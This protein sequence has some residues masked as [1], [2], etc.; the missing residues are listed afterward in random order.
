YNGTTNR[1]VFFGNDGGLYQAGDVNMVQGTAGWTN[2]NHGLGITQFYGAA[3]NLTTGRVVG[4][5]QDN[6]TL[7]FTPAQGPQQW[8]TIYG[9]D[10]GESAADPYQQYYYGEY[11]YLQLHRS[12]NGGASQDIFH[13]ITDAGQNALFIAPFVLDPNNSSRMLAGGG[14][15]WR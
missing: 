2:L 9:G 12:T 1:M 5:A 4:G 11:I 3:G 10:G 8:G 6:R 7:L 13:G 15:V 14:Q